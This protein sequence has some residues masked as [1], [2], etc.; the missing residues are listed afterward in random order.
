[1][2]INIKEYVELSDR[3]LKHEK[4][5]ETQ[6]SFYKVLAVYNIF[7]GIETWLVT[8]GDENWI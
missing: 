5:K 1:M 8:K 6:I 2:S 4:W 3:F 7:Y